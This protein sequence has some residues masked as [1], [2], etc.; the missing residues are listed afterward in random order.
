MKIIQDE[1]IVPGVP[2][3]DNYLFCET[4]GIKSLGWIKYTFVGTYKEMIKYLTITIRA[5]IPTAKMSMPKNWFF[6]IT[7]LEIDDDFLDVTFFGI[8]PPC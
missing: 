1:S 2:I 5:P 8:W 3:Y 4:P 7:G 6:M